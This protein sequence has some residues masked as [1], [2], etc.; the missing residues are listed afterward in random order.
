M[1]NNI[2][3]NRSFGLVFFIFFLI[4]FC[5]DFFLNKNLNFYFLL[6]SLIFLILG[7]L[8]SKLLYPLNKI[9]INIG[10]LLG[11]FVTPIILFILYF[12]IVMP[13]NLILKIF[14]KDIMRLKYDKNKKSYWELREK[15]PNS[16]N[17]QF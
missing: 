5:Y 7:I 12:S 9:W 14:G 1:N 15:K 13:T 2:S 10:N 11:K 6:A 16:M 3:S 8:N 17:N 4:I